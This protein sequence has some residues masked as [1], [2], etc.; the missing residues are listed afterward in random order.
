[1]MKWIKKWTVEGSYHHSTLL[2]VFTTNIFVSEALLASALQLE[3]QVIYHH[4]I[5]SS[6][7]N[8]KI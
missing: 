3:E 8:I 5:F 7:L 4:Q 2:A 6:L 1:M